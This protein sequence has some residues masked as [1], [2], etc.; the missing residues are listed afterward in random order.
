MRC[1]RAV[2]V[3]P[4]P[5]GS[6]TVGFETFPSPVAP[7]SEKTGKRSI[8]QCG[9]GEYRCDDGQCIAKALHCD[10]KYDCADGSDEMKCDY[11]LA[12][13]RQREGQQHQQSAQHRE[14]ILTL[15]HE[16]SEEH[17]EH[18]QDLLTDDEYDEL[19]GECTDQEFRCPYLAETKC[20]HYDKLCDGVDDCGDGSDEANCESGSHEDREYNGAQETSVLA[21]PTAHR[22]APHQ[23]TC[24]DDKSLECDR[25]YDCSDGSD[26]TD[27][28]YYKEAMSRRRSNGHQEE[29]APRRDEEEMRRREELRRREEQERR[30]EEEERR[31]EEE[32]RR[33]EMIEQRREEE[34]RRRGEGRHPEEESRRRDEEEERRR[35]EEER[36]RVDEERRRVEEERRRV[37]EERRRLEDEERRSGEGLRPE[38][39]SRRREEEERRRVEEERRR[40]E[41]ERRRL[42][43]ERRRAEEEA[44]RG[45][46]RGHPE[47]E[48]RRREEEERRRMEEERRRMEEERRREQEQAQREE[49]LA[50]REEAQRREEH[51][52]RLLEAKRRQ[53]EEERRREDEQRRHQ[54]HT[55]SPPPVQFRED[56]DEELPC[57]D[58]EFQCHSGEC[59]DKRRLCD[60]RVDCVDG[61]DESH[62]P[63]RHHQ[64]QPP[65]PPVAPPPPSTSRDQDID[66]EGA[67]EV[68]ISV[69]PTDA[70]VREGREVV[71]DCRARTA[72]NTYYPPTRWTRVGGPLPPHAHESSGR[73]TINPVSLSDAGQYVCVASHG[74]RTVEAQAALHVQSCELSGLSRVNTFAGDFKLHQRHPLVRSARREKIRPPSGSFVFKHFN[75]LPQ[76]QSD[77]KLLFESNLINE[78]A[79]HFTGA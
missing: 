22:C 62:C 31:R 14:R 76:V 68:Q 11:F 66:H 58:H 73:L 24:S 53:E 19:R 44:R 65:P 36:R 49:E 39:E 57:L 28:D 5:D 75:Y 12:S 61:S 54:A 77:Q 15:N 41:E 17:E 27:C 63:G 33:R 3:A 78:A 42:I 30:R 55:E 69:Y 52:R 37:E 4:M 51:E 20:F 64:V 23:F 32:E 2:V 13:L 1:G 71:F 46:E 72:D 70:Q 25:K 38:E 50:R 40:V 45:G 6:T 56:Y 16:H 59:I 60:A 7:V 35:V 8:S 10:R 47:Q 34:E 79:A 67:S 48:S 29:Q 9:S 43:E 74:G 18:R 21:D 26:E